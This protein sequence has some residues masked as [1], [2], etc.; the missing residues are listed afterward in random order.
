[1]NTPWLRRRIAV[2]TT[3]VAGFFGGLVVASP[4][5][6]T[7]GN[8]YGC[9]ANY[10]CVWDVSPHVNV[11]PKWKLYVPNMSSCAWYYEPDSLWQHAMSQ[12]NTSGYRLQAFNGIDGGTAYVYPHTGPNAMSVYWRS[13]SAIRRC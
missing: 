13:I 6:A 1:V 5:L 8:L 9:A 11:A 7:D 10:Y 3:V 4:A 12:A 2:M